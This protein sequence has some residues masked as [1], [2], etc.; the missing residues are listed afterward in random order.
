MPTFRKRLTDILFLD[1]ETVSMVSDFRVLSD[2]MQQL[3]SIKARQLSRD[4]SLAIQDCEDLF[5]KKA[6]IYAEFAKVVCIS[7]GYFEGSKKEPQAFRVKSFYKG[8]E[9][10]ILLSFIELLQA[11]FDKPKQQAISGHNI[12]EFDIPFLCRRMVI[13]ALKVPK[14]LDIGGKKPWQV[15]HLLDT[16]VLWRFGDYK[17][18]TSLRLLAAILGIPSPKGD[19]D[20]S[21]V[22][23]VYWEDND[24]DRIWHY[25]ERD[26]FTSAQVFLKLNRIEVS[27]E[28]KYISKTE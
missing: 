14:M 11:H 28:L 12:K 20:G 6:G 17:H 26:V 13:H 22:S 1:I 9:K 3:W 19:I 24:I 23:K 15:E 7:V 27:P 8:S 5:A 4:P 18:Y 16:L 25:C 21:Q 10:E 2:E